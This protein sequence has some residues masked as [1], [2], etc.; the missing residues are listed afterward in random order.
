MT[1]PFGLNILS[2]PSI[3]RAALLK[4]VNHAKPGLME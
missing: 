4:W 2:Q 1:H 3:D